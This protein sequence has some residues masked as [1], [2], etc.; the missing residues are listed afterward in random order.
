MS[1]TIIKYCFSTMRNDPKPI[2]GL[3]QNNGYLV[4]PQTPLNGM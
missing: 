3:N 4:P 2:R 1:S